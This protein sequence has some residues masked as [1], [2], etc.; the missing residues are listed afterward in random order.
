MK[1]EL[2][3]FYFLIKDKKKIINIY[4]IYYKKIKKKI[5]NIKMELNNYSNILLK[6]KKKNILLNM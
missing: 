4:N 5:Y 3:K 2:E 1:K 6:Y